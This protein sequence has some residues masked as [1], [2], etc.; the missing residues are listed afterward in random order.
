MPATLYG[1]TI[2]LE[3]DDDGGMVTDVLVIARHVR[4]TDDGHTEDC[5]S[6]SATTSTGRIMQTGMIHAAADAISKE[7]DL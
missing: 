7:D 1:R 3:P 4:L 2:D 5:I 6:I